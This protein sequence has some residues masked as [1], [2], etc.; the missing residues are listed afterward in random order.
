ME[1]SFER[2]REFANKGKLFALENRRISNQ[3]TNYKG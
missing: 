2:L 3:T 1:L